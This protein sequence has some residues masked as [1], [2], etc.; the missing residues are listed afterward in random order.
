MKEIKLKRGKVAFVDDEDFEFINQWEW[1]YMK[2]GNTFY[3]IRNER[4]GKNKYKLISMHRVIMGTPKGMEV[5]HVNHDGLFNIKINLKNCTHKENMR[6]ISVYKNNSSGAK[7]VYWHARQRKW[8]AQIN[9]NGKRSTVDA[10]ANKID[11]TIAYNEA[12]K[13]HYGEFASLNRV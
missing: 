2:S 10:Y 8:R 5:D 7:G 12:A 9:I 6:N 3:A 13:K 4:T 11:A 1:G